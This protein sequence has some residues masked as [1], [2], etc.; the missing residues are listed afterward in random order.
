MELPLEF[1]LYSTHLYK[2][3]IATNLGKRGGIRVPRNLG[4]VTKGTRKKTVPSPT[5]ISYAV[6][7]YLF[8]YLFGPDE[9]GRKPLVFFGIH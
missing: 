2:E 7:R 4:L 3:G 6:V 8:F 9:R 1:Y 5:A